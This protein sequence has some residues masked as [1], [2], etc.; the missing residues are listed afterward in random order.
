MSTQVPNYY[1]VLFGLG[2]I[3]NTMFA[4]VDQVCVGGGGV[5]GGSDM[6]S[7]PHL[8]DQTLI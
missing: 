4:G 6:P 2:A 1:T 7:D 8:E 5:M 3:Y